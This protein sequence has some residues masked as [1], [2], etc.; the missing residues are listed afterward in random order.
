MFLGRIS[1]RPGATLLNDDYKIHRALRTLYADGV[2]PLWRLENAKGVPTLIVVSDRPARRT[3]GLPVEIEERPYD[4]FLHT[5]ET[6]QKFKFRIRANMV[7]NSPPTLDGNR[8]I[9]GKPRPITDPEEQEQ[10][11]VSRL[12][13]AGA[14]ARVKRSKS[15][16]TKL[17]VPTRDQNHQVANP[18]NVAPSTTNTF[19]GKLTITNP[20]LF[21]AALTSGI[22]RQRAFGCGLLTIAR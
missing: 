17:P 16:F 7:R 18:T 22:G 2:H 9:R 13:A 12:A 4:P 20:A 21:A 6:G 11:I 1:V 14:D 5:L 10:W 8:L 15:G 19:T 3:T